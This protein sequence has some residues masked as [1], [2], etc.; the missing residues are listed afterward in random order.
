[1]KPVRIVYQLLASTLLLVSGACSQESPGP[2][3]VPPPPPPPPRT[4]EV[5]MWLTKADQSGLLQKQN[6]VIYFADTTNS[7]PVIDVD[8]AT[9]YQKVDGFGYTL[10]GAS[11]YLLNSM[12]S[13]KTA[14]LQEL[15]G[16]GATGIGVSYLRISIGASDLSAE[17]FSYND[18]PEGQTDLQLEK[19]SLS[20][21]TVD[22]IPVLKEILAINPAIKIMGSPWSPPVWMKDNKSSIGGSLLP[23]Y[24]PVY[25]NYFVKY[26]QEMKAQGITVDAITIQNEPQHGGNNPSLVMSAEQQADFVKNHLGPAFQSAGIKTKIV[27]WDHNCDN[28]T[29]PISILNDPDAKKFIDGSAFHLYAGDIS[30][31]STVH[32]AHPDKAL[33]F[34]EQWTSS[35]GDFAGDLKWH[36]KN[37]MI[38]SMRNWS[39][40][41]LEWNL[42][43]NTSFGPHTPGGCTE[44][45][46]ALTINGASFTRNVSFYIIAHAS[47]FIPAGSERIASNMVSNLP[48]VV[49]KRPDGKKVMLIVNEAS[50]LTGFNI[51]YK[52]KL[53]FTSLPA[54]GVGTFIW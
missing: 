53:A 43:N 32:T 45:K 40:V 10:T 44:C 13:G 26:I 5:E 17:V 11:A 33:Y 46:G 16:T 4:N 18:L 15:F 39:K 27:I 25:A 21:D 30:A 3:V 2:S 9:S 42:A 8:S 37:V 29:Y 1:M 14:L 22:L 48:N 35:K 38:G 49:F 20:K 6:T 7:Y 54:G 47:K 23:Q 36:V 52:G 19:F 31:L 12:G 41:A 51:K 34:T 28:P 50:T 24:Y